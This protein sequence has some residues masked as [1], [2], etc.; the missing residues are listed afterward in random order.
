M[1]IAKQ[2]LEA[3]DHVVA[4]DVEGAFVDAPIALDATA[5]KEYGKEGGSS[6]KRFIREN[7]EL[8]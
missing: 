1:S 4:G 2:V 7:L 6:Y 5:T 3:I 8:M